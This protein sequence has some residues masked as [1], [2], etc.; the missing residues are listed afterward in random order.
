MPW[1]PPPFARRDVRIVRE[2]FHTERVTSRSKVSCSSKHPDTHTY[3]S[4]C[5]SALLV[6]VTFRFRCF[7]NF[8]IHV[9]PSAAWQG[10]V[11]RANEQ[12]AQRIKHIFLRTDTTDTSVVAG[13][14]T[15]GGMF[16]KNPSLTPRIGAANGP[17]NVSIFMCGMR[18]LGRQR[19]GRRAG[20]AAKTWAYFLGAPFPYSKLEN[21]VAT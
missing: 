4:V 7:A 10:R 11:S 12:G 2:G 13:G 5:V 3:K 18:R 21:I 19:K 9:Q 1:L 16:Q 17:A 20:A 6:P 8:H 15:T 14:R